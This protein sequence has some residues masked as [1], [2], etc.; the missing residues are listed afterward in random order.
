MPRK[1]C[2]SVCSGNNRIGHKNRFFCTVENLIITD[3]LGGF[4]PATM[5]PPIAMTMYYLL[6]DSGHRNAP[7]P[8]LGGLVAQEGGIVLQKK[9]FYRADFL[10]T[11]CQL[12]LK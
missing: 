2:L 7:R 1:H 4:A 11:H 5:A 8:P 6:S 10:I 3:A 9:D 12:V